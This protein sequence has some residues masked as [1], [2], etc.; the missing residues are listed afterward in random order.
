MKLPREVKILI[1][2]DGTVEIETFGFAGASCVDL[3]A[4]LEAAFTDPD[5]E[6]SQVERNLKPEC[7]ISEIAPAIE[8][9]D[10]EQ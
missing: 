3:S 9:D 6:A 7:F 8:L 1:R 2:P 4:V 5:G 10:Y